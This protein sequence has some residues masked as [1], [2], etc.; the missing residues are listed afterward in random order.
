MEEPLLV[1][2]SFVFDDNKGLRNTHEVV[3]STA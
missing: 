3:V 1:S 2:E